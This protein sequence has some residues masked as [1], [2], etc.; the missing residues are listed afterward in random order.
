MV[1]AQSTQEVQKMTTEV[2]RAPRTTGI[3]AWLR[4]SVA[5]GLLAL[6]LVGAVLVFSSDDSSTVPNAAVRAGSG[7]DDAAVAKGVASG[8]TFVPAHPDE[9]RTAAA[10]GRSDGEAEDVPPGSG[11][12]IGRTP[13]YV[14]EQNLLPK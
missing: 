3:G 7:P 6:A 8:R 13:N 14:P 2:L 4:I 10:I 9:A 1:A 12:S 11:V 5:I